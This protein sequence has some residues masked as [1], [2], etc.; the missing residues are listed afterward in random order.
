MVGYGAVTNIPLI[1][2]A[3]DHKAYFSL[4]LLIIIDH[5]GS[6]QCHPHLGNRLVEQP[7]S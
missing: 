2:V 3:S 4:K 1:S 7:L 5:L 6:I